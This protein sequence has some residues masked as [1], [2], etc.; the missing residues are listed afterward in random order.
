MVTWVV[1]GEPN[2]YSLLEGGARGVV[3]N[4][5]LALL[6]ALTK[7]RAMLCAADAGRGSGV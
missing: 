5:P 6:Q 4:R 7:R 2:A 1:D 3:S